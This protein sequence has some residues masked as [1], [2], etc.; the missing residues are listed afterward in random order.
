MSAAAAIL[1]ENRSLRLQRPRNAD[2]ARKS[3]ICPCPVPS[4]RSPSMLLSMRIAWNTQ[5]S[6]EALLCRIEAAV[7]GGRLVREEP[8]LRRHG[9]VL[10]R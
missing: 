4:D 3:G 2:L 9:L 1:Q 8:F 7:L 6:T 5:Q 10:L